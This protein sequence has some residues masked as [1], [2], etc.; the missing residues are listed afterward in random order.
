MVK[1]NDMKALNKVLRLYYLENLPQKE[2]ANKLNISL[3]NV[4]EYLDYARD[5]KLIEVKLNVPLDESEDSVTES[6]G[7]ETECN[8]CKVLEAKLQEKFGIKECR[9]VKSFPDAKKTL[10]AMAIELGQMLEGILKDGDYLGVGWGTTL[11]AMARYLWMRKKINV[12][13][14]PIAAGTEISGLGSSI[15]FVNRFIANKIGGVS[16]S[17]DIPSILDS[18]EAK[19]AVLT[20]PNTQELLALTKK[21]TVGLVSMSGI[22]SAA[23]LF[24][25]SRLGQQEI[26]YL[27]GLGIIGNINFAFFDKN[28]KHIPN[29]FEERIVDVFPLAFMKKTENMIGVSFGDNKVDVMR[30]ALKGKILHRL[31]TDEDTAEKVLSNNQ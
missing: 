16:Y 3:V 6:E 20:N 4:A 2:V 12:H 14:V 7:L 24:K 15:N 13:V 23:T 28:G 8:A 18:R 1:H 10:K 22:S 17:M 29:K 26:K 19:E 27:Q 31:I 25:K 21:I 11:E 30:A 5:H 9:I